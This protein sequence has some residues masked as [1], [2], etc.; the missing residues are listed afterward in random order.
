MEYS[1]VDEVHAPGNGTWH[2]RC[3]QYSTWKEFNNK[4]KVK[5]GPA[6]QSKNIS[7]TINQD[8]ILSIEKAIMKR[9][10]I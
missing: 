8:Q 5:A 9:V 1:V 3:L 7:I 4:G 10:F 2:Q 6:G